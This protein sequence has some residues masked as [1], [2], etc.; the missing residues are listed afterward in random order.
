MTAPASTPAVLGF[1][2]KKFAIRIASVAVDGTGAV[3]H[4]AALTRW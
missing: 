2:L 3:I 1:V 4:M